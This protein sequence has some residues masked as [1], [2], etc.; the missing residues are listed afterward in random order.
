MRPSCYILFSKL[1]LQGL[2]FGARPTVAGVH[3]LLATAAL[4]FGSISIPPA[5]GSA[6]VN[7]VPGPVSC[8]RSFLRDQPERLLAGTPAE[9]ELVPVD[10][11]GNVGALGGRFSAAL[12]PSNGGCSVECAVRES[13][14]GGLAGS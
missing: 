4:P 12:L 3:T 8:R 13:T 1:T 7:V 14:T 5:H 10:D 11:F 2:R 9:V 6:S